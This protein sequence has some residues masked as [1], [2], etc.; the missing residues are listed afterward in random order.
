VARSAK[1]ALALR[2]ALLRQLHV[3]LSVFVAPSL[4]F[5]ALTG[6]LQTFRIPDR[7]DAPVVVQKLARVHRDSVFAAKARPAP[8]QRS[9][10]K[11]P[12]PPKSKPPL[13]TTILKWF[14]VVVSLGM[15]A[16]A[17]LGVW[18]AVA[19]HR[20]KALMWGLLAAGTAFPVLLVLL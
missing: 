9:V 5:F 11:A 18:M 2:L 3:Y 20:E 4:I 12:A 14:F 1:G 10:P 19:H 16:S 17:V 6:A 8:A 7:S 13:A 15:T